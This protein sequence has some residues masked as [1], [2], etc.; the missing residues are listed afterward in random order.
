MLRRVVNRMLRIEGQAIEP[1]LRIE[2]IELDQLLAAVVAGLA[3]RLQWTETK[4]IPIASVW[5]DV[6]SDASWCRSPLLQTER[7]QGF[8]LELILGPLPMGV[9][10]WPISS[11][12][13]D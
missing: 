6:V 1:D 2:P 13:I 3:E 12:T 7:T 5:G 11:A 9:E 8:D 10:L 4:V